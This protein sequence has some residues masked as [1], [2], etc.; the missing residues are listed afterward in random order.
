M[1]VGYKFCNAKIIIS[2]FQDLE[3]IIQRDFFPDLAKL[4]AQ[5]EYIEAVEKNDLVRMRELALRYAA[6]GRSR[7]DTETP[8]PCM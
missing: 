6:T 2:L 4:R 5:K 7:P 8:T 3:K 1:G